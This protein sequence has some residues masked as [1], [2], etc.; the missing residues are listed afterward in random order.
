MAHFRLT[1]QG[2]HRPYDLGD[3][4]NPLGT[5][6]KSE[7]NLFNQESKKQELIKQ[8]EDSSMNR[9]HIKLVLVSGLGFLIDSYHLSLFT[10]IIPMLKFIYYPEMDRFPY[11]W[12]VVLITNCYLGVIIGLLYFGYMADC[13]GRKKIY[14]ITTSIT[15]IGSLGCCFCSNTLRGINVLDGLMF[16]QFIVGIGIGGDFV[17]SGLIAIE[18]SPLNLRGTMIASSFIFYSFGNL[19]GGTLTYVIL[20]IYKDAINKDIFILDN[21]WRILTLFGALLSLLSLLIRC[22]IPETLR[23]TLQVKQNFLNGIKTIQQ[24]FKTNLK[25]TIYEDKLKI[26]LSELMT[27]SFN[28]SSFQPNYPTLR[29]VIEFIRR[30]VKNIKLILFL[31]LS[32]FTLDFA[33]AGT[34]LNNSGILSYLGYSDETSGY[35]TLQH[36]ALGN[37]MLTLMGGIPGVILS[38]IIIDRVGRVRLQK[39]CFFMLIVIYIILSAVFYFLNNDTPK[40]ILSII[41]FSLA[42][43]FINLGPNITIL[44][45]ALESF[46][47]RYR[48][49]CLAIPASFGKLGSIF[50]QISF[51]NFEDNPA[52]FPLLLFICTIVMMLGFLVS[53]S[54]KETKSLSLPE[55][56]MNTLLHEA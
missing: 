42:R 24:V 50:S 22:T 52:N 54:L 49:L 6:E 12:E 40:S 10:F 26:Q 56:S 13:Y 23:Y 35:L 29:E 7:I 19:I 20:Y 28:L 33:Y 53:L 18:F 15:M 25:N 17:I 16:W 9:F 2:K 30:D 32:W 21:I 37:I 27:S 1:L 14:A 46:P 36:V 8:I 55:N 5:S 34:T 38:A 44:I 48:G 4:Q 39:I 3:S 45:L 11:C 41:F 51:I 31:S 43:F 47:T